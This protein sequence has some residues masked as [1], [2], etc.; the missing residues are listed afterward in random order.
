MWSDGGAIIEKEIIHDNNESL[1]DAKRKIAKVSAAKIYKELYSSMLSSDNFKEQVSKAPEIADKIAAFE[2]ID[3]VS[4]FLDLDIQAALEYRKDPSNMYYK[5]PDE[6]AVIKIISEALS[7]KFDSSL[8][9]INKSMNPYGNPRLRE[10]FN[11]METALDAIASDIDLLTYRS[12][13]NFKYES[14]SS[15]LNSLAWLSSYIDKS[16]ATKMSF[17]TNIDLLATTNI[18]EY[19][20]LSITE[21]EAKNLFNYVN[22]KYFDGAFGTM[23]AFEEFTNG[24]FTKVTNNALRQMALPP[25][26]TFE[27]LALFSI[28]ALLEYSNPSKK[29]E[30]ESI[31]TSLTGNT[32]VS[33]DII[34]KI[35]ALA[36]ID[37]KK[38]NRDNNSWRVAYI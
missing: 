6:I 34:D 5:H 12:N 31:V 22:S 16:R 11:S 17:L 28:V 9:D 29:N 27:K 37:A 19:L 7:E 36:G 35:K 10:N 33:G 15:I 30:A 21:T 1:K 23:E 25:S 14:M 18:S 32:D 38:G 4:S 24:S 20:L 13:G 26:S 8:R 2:D 3:M